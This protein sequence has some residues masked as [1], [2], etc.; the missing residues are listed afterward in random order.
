MTYGIRL[1]RKKYTWFAEIPPRHVWVDESEGMYTTKNKA[2]RWDTAD[3]AEADITEPWEY[4]A[5]L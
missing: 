3:D 4:V 5:E 2:K 1:N